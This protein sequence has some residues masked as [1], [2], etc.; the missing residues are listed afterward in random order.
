MG[1]TAARLQWAPGVAVLVADGE[2]R[3]F[4]SLNALA[5]Q[6]TGTELPVEALFD[7]LRGRAADAPG[8]VAD[9]TSINQGRV[10]AVREAGALPRVELRLVLQ[11]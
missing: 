2:T 1:T 11:P 8:W 4:D 3:S 10:Y 9:L 5:L 7:W 6:A